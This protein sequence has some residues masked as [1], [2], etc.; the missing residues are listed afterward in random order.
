MPT[1]LGQNFLVNK[2]IAKKIVEAAELKP[3]DV[4]LEIG[5]GKGILTEELAKKA[6]KVIAV[7]IDGN[8]VEILENKFKNKKN[9]E[10]IKGD[11]LQLTTYNLQLT[12]YKIVANLPYY[13]TSPVI[14]K[15]L[16]SENPPSKM[17]LMLQKEVAERI[18]ASSG[19][20]SILA[21]S[22]Q[23]YAQPQVIF[24]VPRE[25]FDPAPEV[26]SA[27]IHIKTLKQENIKT[28]EQKSKESKKFFRVVKAGFCAKR[29]TLINNLANSFH[30]EKKEV[31]EKLKRVGI[32]SRTRAQELSVKDWKKLAE[33][34]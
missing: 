26:D 23:Y 3:D 8:L 2:D 1:K 7:E 29:K 14:R 11:V 9:V 10:I 28:K 27:V 33:L 16:E 6:G 4:V 5:P 25:N 18:V 17:I 20:M 30:L 22:V 31:E 15:F 32:S 34:F 24:N 21:V 19:K 13:I 12:T